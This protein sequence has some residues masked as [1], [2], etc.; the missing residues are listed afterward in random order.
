MEVLSLCIHR[1]INCSPCFR[2]HWRCDQLNLSHL[3]FADDLLLFCNGDE[4]SV[5]TLHDA[6]SDFESLS[7][8]TASVSK[9]KIF[10]SGVDVNSTE[11]ILRIMNFHVGT[12]PV[13]YLGIPLITT[14]LRMQDCS[15]LIDRIEARIKSWENKVLSFAG[16]L[17]LI[18]SVLSSIQ[19]YWA[20]HL[21]LPKK[22]LKDIEKRLRCFLWAGNCSGKAAAKV[23]WSDIC[24]P[25]SEGGLGIKDLH[26]WNKALM[27]R[28]IWNLVSGSSNLWT[29]W[30]KVYLLRNNS[31][32]NAPHPAVCSWNW[33]KMLKI[34][35]LCRSFFA[36]IIGDGRS[37][38]LW[39]DNWHPLGPLTLRWSSNI[40][41]DSALSTSAM[42]SDVIYNNN[43]RWPSL[44]HE[45]LEI[46]VSLTQIIPNSEV[47]DSVRWTLSSNGVY[48]TS[49]AWNAL[50]FSR[51][52]VPWY[53]L[54]WFGS[55]VPR[56]S[57]IL[58]LAI[59]G[60]LSTM[61][62]H[63][64]PWAAANWKGKS[65]SIAIK[66]L[67]L[68][69]AVYAIWR[70]RNNRK[71]RNESLPSAVVFKAIV[72]SMRLCLLSWKI[73]PSPSN[74]YIIHEWRLPS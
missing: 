33:R 3:C 37:T 74:S 57:F 25:K 26:C 13:R 6:L 19:V 43:W 5:L 14:K 29:N 38:S 10:L 27:I 23:A 24:L 18:Q 12:C 60:R 70:E 49:S 1:R 66:K 20:S 32:W 15:P 28:H 41:A 40:I 65:L 53:H 46:R 4:N 56:W 39:F 61:D 62:R 16:R 42:V 34:R 17:Q 45:L 52:I 36:N 7:G 71:F 8:L 50:R 31:F 2:Y 68:Q 22:V 73:P 69:A 35:E 55:C 47:S 9:S 63:F 58:W 64:I 72:E 59:R 48:S 44:S 51:P 67:A 21:I 54:V 11:S 30:V